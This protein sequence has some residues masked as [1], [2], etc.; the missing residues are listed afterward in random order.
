[1][2]QVRFS[3]IQ[4]REYERIAGDNPSVCGG[5]PIGIN[6]GYI[7]VVDCSITSYEDQRRPK[8]TLRQLCLTIQQRWKL[9]MEWGIPQGEMLLAIRE[10]ARAKQHRQLSKADDI[11][12]RLQ[13]EDWKE[14]LMGF[15]LSKRP[16]PVV[17]SNRRPTTTA[18]LDV[19]SILNDPD[20]ELMDDTHSVSSTDEDEDLIR[21]QLLDYLHENVKQVYVDM[22][23]FASARLAL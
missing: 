17:Q 7:L 12:L 23:D 18:R 2:K 14:S 6:D 11:E 4:I 13:R 16:T 5:C 1:M 9:L 3:S 10:A 22:D 8:R 21:E 19:K 15:F 20:R